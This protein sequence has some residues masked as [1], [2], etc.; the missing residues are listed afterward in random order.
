MMNEVVRLYAVSYF[1]FKL[2]ENMLEHKPGFLLARDEREAQESANERKYEVFLMAEGWIGQSAT[3][4]GFTDAIQH[5]V[6]RLLQNGGVL[7]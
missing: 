7:A 2:P 1:A 5:N 3:V 4:I 6:P